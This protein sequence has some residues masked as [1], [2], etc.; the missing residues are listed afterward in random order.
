MLNLFK[1]KITYHATSG[2]V[3]SS[4]SPTSALLFGSGANTTVTNNILLPSIVNN[5]SGTTRGFKQK[6]GRVSSNNTEDKQQQHSSQ[7]GFSANSGETRQPTSKKPF[8]SNFQQ[9]S[10]NHNK[11]HH[12]KS[13]QNYKEKHSNHTTSTTSFQKDHHEEPSRNFK[14]NNNQQHFDKSQ[15]KGGFN[16][17]DDK[18]QFQ[19]HKKHNM[20]RKPKKQQSETPLPDVVSN[21]EE[22]I[23]EEKKNFVALNYDNIDMNLKS[24]DETHQT[25]ASDVSPFYEGNEHSSEFTPFTKELE[26]NVDILLK[27]VLEKVKTQ[28]AVEIDKEKDG[29]SSLLRATDSAIKEE[30]DDIF[31][32]RDFSLIEETDE[33]EEEQDFVGKKYDTLH[34][35]PLELKKKAS[36]EKEEFSEK[37]SAE[38]LTNAK[39]IP[40]VGIKYR[41][42]N[43]DES[44]PALHKYLVDFGDSEY[45]QLAETH[46]SEKMYVG[47]S[48]INQVPT[49][50][51]GLNRVLT[52]PGVHRMYDG[53]TKTHFFHPYMR[54]LHKPEEI[55]FNN[56]TPFIPPS[57]DTT[58][59]KLMDQN[60]CRYQ[61]STSS[62]TSPLVSLYL[63][64]SNYKPTR[65]RNLEN[66]KYLTSSF[67]PAV[68]KPVVFIL[69]PKLS[70]LGHTFYSIDSYKFLFEPRSNQILMDL[71]KVMEK[72]FVMEP[73]D[74]EKRFVKQYCGEEQT[75]EDEEVY[76]YL[77]HG[78]FLLR[79]QLD[80]YHPQYGVFDI[81]TRAT[82]P[83]RINMEKY[84]KFTNIKLKMIKGNYNS[85]EREFYDMVRSV[86]IKYSMQGRIGG[87]DGMFLAYHN[88]VE[89]FG[90]EYIKLGEIDK[91]VFGSPHMAERFFSLLLDLLGEVLDRITE[92]FAGQALKVTFRPVKVE[93]YFIDIF[94]EPVH[95]DLGWNERKPTEEEK[96]KWESDRFNA[97]PFADMIEDTVYCYRLSCQPMVNGAVC[98]NYVEFKEEDK[99]DILYCLEEMGDTTTDK[100][101][102]N[103]YILTLKKAFFVE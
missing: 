72:L 101:L 24:E 36:R 18:A 78:S 15:R 30:D 67:T 43:N 37:Q 25:S 33:A 84:Q 29:L 6:F 27:R 90:F 74:F 44:L 58:L 21:V 86:F 32:P 49:L 20:E 1:K 54:Q 45:L 7:H 63:A 50:K 82:N 55:N 2:L 4:S 87:M 69:R 62:I 26:I 13:Q 12:Q 51:N 34:K 3:A 22:P 76:R 9:N 39:Y 31:Q 11:P 57:Q 83:I 60:P 65:A 42:K 98:R 70:K 47:D 64:L 28:N 14:F 35:K 19:H 85:Y 61:S 48:D 91:H 23:K 16:K 56:L 80:C 68:R 93:P 66:F 103:E 17:R 8:K 97:N 5:N 53:K 95:G 40:S 46:P 77:R 38:V 99:V 73:E 92:K 89:L 59:H 100:F 75:V 88:T 52:S 102:L 71:G 96:M 10:N 94:V 41:S 79:S 81:K